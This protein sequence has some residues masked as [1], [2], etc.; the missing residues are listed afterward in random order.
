MTLSF[1]LPEEASM[2]REAVREFAEKEIAPIAG[3]LDEKEEFSPELTKKMGDLGLLGVYLP[4]EYGG[5][6][7]SYLAYIVAVEELAR[8]DGSQA[9]TIAAHNSLGIGPIY[10]FGSKEQK[11]KYLPQLTTGEKLW[12]FGL[13]EPEAGSDAGASKTKAVK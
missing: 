3:D 7:L 2:M 13:T 10:Y 4:E 8:V 9:A 1:D 11:E 6:E 12:G 5:S